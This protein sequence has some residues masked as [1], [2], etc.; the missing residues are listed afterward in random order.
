MLVPLHSSVVCQVLNYKKFE[1]C[2]S[3]KKFKE[4]KEEICNKNTVKGT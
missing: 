1:I 2:S 3:I 4:L